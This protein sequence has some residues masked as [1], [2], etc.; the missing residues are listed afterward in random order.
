MGYMKKNDI[1]ELVRQ[2]AL[3]AAT[4]AKNTG[5]NIYKIVDNVVGYVMAN[6]IR[7]KKCAL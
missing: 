5:G 2:T 1:R 3:L 6:K 4:D 7:G